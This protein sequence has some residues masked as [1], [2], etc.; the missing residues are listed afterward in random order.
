MARLRFKLISSGMRELQHEDGVRR[1]L[2]E[3]A[4][5]ALNEMRRLVPVRTGALRDS[6]RLVDDTTD[7]PVVRIV[8]DLPYAAAIN[9]ATGF[10]SRG[11]DA[12]R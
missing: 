4:D 7:R 5:P 11:L 1:R 6:L 10:M 12:A 2:R 8:S 9:A 3:A